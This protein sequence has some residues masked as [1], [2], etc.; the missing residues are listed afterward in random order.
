[1][2]TFTPTP[3]LAR[4]ITALS[5]ELDQTPF[6]QD[7]YWPKWNH[8]WWKLTLLLELK[9][10]DQLAP[11]TLPRWAAH[12]NRH[13]LHHF[14]LHESELP[15]GCDPYREILCFCALGTAL[16]ILLA[17]GLDPWHELPWAQ[18]WLTR[19]QMPDG[20]YNCDEQAYT[21]SHKSSLVSSLPML[22][23][24]LLSRPDG[25]WT[26]PETQILNAGAQYLLTHRLTER[27]SGGVIDPRW[28][29][30]VFPRF[31]EYDSLRALRFL[32][33]WS[34]QSQSALPEAA[35]QS[36]WEALQ[37]QGEPLHPQRWYLAD[38]T[39]LRQ[40]EGDWQRGQ[41]SDL[42]PLLAQ[43]SQP[44]IGQLWI[45]AEWQAVQENRRKMQSQGLIESSF[46]SYS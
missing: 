34:L 46:S 39:T 11:T 12:L 6:D 3:D 10:L 45:Q 27:R 44:E 38:E 9:A 28:L 43:I 42:F 30:P 32:T 31:Y 22:E 5:Q 2:P 26:P 15:S 33:R 40:L 29:Q 36:S 35:L 4:A 19:Y 8:S 18:D 37:S 23:A 16:Q 25:R 14:P 20:G 1:M 17:G 41:A 7:P 24:L 21:G 13:Y